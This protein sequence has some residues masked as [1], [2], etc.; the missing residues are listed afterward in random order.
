M[1]TASRR[2]VSIS[3][4]ELV[5]CSAQ[6]L[7]CGALL[8][9]TDDAKTIVNSVLGEIPILC[10]SICEDSCNIDVARHGIHCQAAKGHKASSTDLK[11]HCRGIW[12]A[13]AASVNRLQVVR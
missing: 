10:A 9:G 3:R 8:T 7:W 2:S 13:E 4:K 6:W 5:L 1:Q 12:T 11:A